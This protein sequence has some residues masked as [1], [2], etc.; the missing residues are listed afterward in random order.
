MK[1]DSGDLIALAL[2][3]EF[4]VIIH[5]CNCFNKMGAGFAR[6]VRIHFPEAYAADLKTKYGDPN[7]LGTISFAKVVRA[8][9]QGD[10]NFIG[11]FF[12]VNAYT[13]FNYGAMHHEFDYNALR[14]AFKAVKKE[15]TGLRIGYPMIG[16]GLGKGDWSM[17][18]RVID[19]EL[20]GEDHTVIIYD[21]DQNE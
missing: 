3:G 7:K 9:K 1:S 18:S 4:D 6:D 19:E 13:Q 16:S 12:V 10:V 15:F 8:A 14:N 5:G 20:D 21:G 11:S 17:I 2:Q